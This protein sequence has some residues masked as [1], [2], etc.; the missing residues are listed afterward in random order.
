[1]AEVRHN[2]ESFKGSY[3]LHQFMELMRK[4]NFQ[5]SLIV[6]A[7]TLIADLVFQPISELQ[8]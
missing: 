4:N 6:T 2:N 5:L 3:K 8:F 7:K 1:M